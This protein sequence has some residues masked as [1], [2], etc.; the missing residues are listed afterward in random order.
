MLQENLVTQVYF[1]VWGLTSVFSSLYVISLVAA[2]SK[3][4][5]LVA[6][7]SVKI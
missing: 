7:I 6:T 3:L 5:E 2:A 4:K 1:T